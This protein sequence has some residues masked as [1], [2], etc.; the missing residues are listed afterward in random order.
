MAIVI[1]GSLTFLE[2][3]D[4]LFYA[5][6]FMLCHT[7]LKIYFCDLYNISSILIYFCLT[8]TNFPEM[9]S[10]GEGM[11]IALVVLEMVLKEVK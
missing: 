2:L 4:I 1:I 5:L 9:L 10:V 8:W 6:S 7:L 11:I 3:T